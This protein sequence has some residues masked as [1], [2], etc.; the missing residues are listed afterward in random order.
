MARKTIFKIYNCGC[1]GI[2]FNQYDSPQGPAEDAYCITVCDRSRYEENAGEFDAF[3]VR[4]FA[5]SEKDRPVTP[6]EEDDL[7][8]RFRKQIWDGAKFMALKQLLA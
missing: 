7:L 1:V 3:V 2:P 6:E 4:K 8:S 5:V